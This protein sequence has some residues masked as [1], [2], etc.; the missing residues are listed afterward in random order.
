MNTTIVDLQRFDVPVLAKQAEAARWRERLAYL[1]SL[2]PAERRSQG[3]VEERWRLIR[4]KLM[5][6]PPIFPTEVNRERKHEREQVR[7]SQSTGLDVPTRTTPAASPKERRDGSSKDSTRGSPEDAE[8]DLARHC[9]KCDTTLATGQRKYCSRRCGNAYRQGMY[10]DQHADPVVLDA[11][12]VVVPLKDEP[13]WS[14]DW[15]PRR[16]RGVFGDPVFAEVQAHHLYQVQTAAWS[17]DDTDDD[18]DS[19]VRWSAQSPSRPQCQGGCG[20]VA[21][22]SLPPSGHRCPDCGEAVYWGAVRREA[23]AA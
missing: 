20:W 6:D 12:V 19:G 4:A 21:P 16:R 23:V 13:S 14:R 7:R 8:G 17:D 9:L 15:K 5:A 18:A 3:V 2:T 1:E 11:P 22:S 10:R